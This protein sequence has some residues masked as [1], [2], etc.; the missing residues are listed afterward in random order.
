MQRMGEGSSQ[1]IAISVVVLVVPELS[2]FNVTS[3]LMCSSTTDMGM[4]RLGRLASHLLL[5]RNFYPLV[6]SAEEMSIDMDLF[7]KHGVLSQVPHM[8]IL[9][10]DFKHFIKVPYP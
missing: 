7:V 6:P 4:D 1:S 5:Q 9:P 10:S 3:K 8:L 2:Y